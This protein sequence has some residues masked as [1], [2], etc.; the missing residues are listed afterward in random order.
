MLATSS[1]VDDDSGFWMS[2]NGSVVKDVRGIEE[3][4]AMPRIVGI[5]MF[6]NGH[7]STVVRGVNSSKP[8]HKPLHRLL[9]HVS[10]GIVKH[11][12][13]TEQYIVLNCHVFGDHK[14]RNNICDTHVHHSDRINVKVDFFSKS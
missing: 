5:F 3:H 4:A 14:R 11:R 9:A 1:S 8:F 13:N 6:S 7:I 10:V 12:N 2:C